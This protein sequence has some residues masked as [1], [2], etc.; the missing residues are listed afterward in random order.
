M[1]VCLFVFCVCVCASVPMLG[2]CLVVWIAKWIA[3]Q[4]T[5]VGKVSV[6]R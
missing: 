1:I 3:E 5:F 4:H 6:P 2:V